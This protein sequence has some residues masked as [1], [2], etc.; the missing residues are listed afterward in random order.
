MVIIA[1]SSIG[2]CDIVRDVQK[3]ESLWDNL[4]FPGMLKTC[5]FGNGDLMMS[6]GLTKKLEPI[7]QI[8]EKVIFA[9]KLT[10][11]VALCPFVFFFKNSNIPGATTDGHEEI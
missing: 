1:L 2:G 5:V 6:T 3:N 4:G 11:N 8:K 9:E 7:M 10:N